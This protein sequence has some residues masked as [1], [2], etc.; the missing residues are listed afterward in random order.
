MTD[1]TESSASP[2]TT[3]P[4]WCDPRVCASTDTDTEHSSALVALVLSDMQCDFMVVQTTDHRFPGATPEVRVHVDLIDLVIDE[5]DPACRTTQ[6][7]L[8]VDDWDRFVERVT[9]ER[10]RARFLSTPRGV[11]S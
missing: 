9:I 1:F 4:R 2:A 3:H 8:S 10:N 11:A 5:R 6:V 7:E